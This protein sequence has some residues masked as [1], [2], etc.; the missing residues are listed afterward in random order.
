MKPAWLRPYLIE[1]ERRFRARTPARCI[2]DADPRYR[3]I[4]YEMVAWAKQTL[5]VDLT[6]ADRLLVVRPTARIVRRVLKEHLRPDVQTDG[7]G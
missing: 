4:W 5:N 7:A 6:V 1:F 3:V 2:A